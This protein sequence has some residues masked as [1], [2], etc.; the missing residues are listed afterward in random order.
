MPASFSKVQP[1]R[2][3]AYRFLPCG[4]NGEPRENSQYTTI[5]TEALVVGSRVQF[6]LL[7]YTAWEVVAVQDETRPLLGARDTDGT[8]IPLAGTVVC[9]GIN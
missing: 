1:M 3:V 4:E 8:E 6:A 7:G 5:R 2:K 9:R